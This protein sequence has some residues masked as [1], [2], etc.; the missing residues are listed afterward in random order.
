MAS[1]T[2]S[3]SRPSRRFA[4]SNVEQGDHYRKWNETLAQAIEGSDFTVA[5]G[6]T[7]FTAMRGFEWTN[8]YYNHL[9][10]YFSRNV[11][12]AKDDGSFLSMGV[13]W[14]WLREPAE[15]GGGSDALVVFNH[16]GGQPPCRPST[17]RPA[18]QP[19]PGGDAWRRELGRPG[20]RGRCRR[21][22][23]RDRGQRR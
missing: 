14:D 2:S 19:D 4:C 15:Q 18:A 20:P 13:L 3:S 1:P 22:G 9:G 8:D 7:G 5:D 10:V 12:N 11:V 23:R 17:A 16:P 21:A 6:Y